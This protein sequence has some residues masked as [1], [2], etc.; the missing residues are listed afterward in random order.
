MKIA[1]A[2]VGDPPE[3]P[4]SDTEAPLGP[5]GGNIFAL[6]RDELPSE[7]HDQF[8]R[9]EEA[10]KA[11]PDEDVGD[12]VRTA[13]FFGQK[14]GCYKEHFQKREVSRTPLPEYLGMNPTIPHAALTRAWRRYAF[15][16]GQRNPVPLGNRQTVSSVVGFALACKAG[17]GAAPKSSRN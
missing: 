9:L 7:W 2:T 4:A 14:E 16:G 6:L 1:V 5:V 17:G 11:R 12:Q 3:E 13:F 15:G 10:R 8:T